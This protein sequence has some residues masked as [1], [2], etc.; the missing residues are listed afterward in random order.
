MTEND[1]A[2]HCLDYYASKQES[3]GDDG[4]KKISVQPESGVKECDSSVANELFG[5]I[6]DDINL[7]DG[8]V[9][10]RERAC[11]PVVQNDTSE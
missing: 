6:W 8:I 7:K 9:E 5:P 10:G 1:Y 4:A 11:D 3:M 2:R